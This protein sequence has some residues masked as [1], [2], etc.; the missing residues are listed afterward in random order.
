MN[1]K[2]TTPYGEEAITRDL[3]ALA[4]LVKEGF[5]RMEGPSPRVLQAIH[6]EAIAQSI[7]RRAHH[8]FV[9]TARFAVAAAVLVL[10]CGVSLQSWRSWH[11]VRHDAQ[12]VQLLRLSTQGSGSGEHELADSSELANFLLSMQ[13]FDRDS[14]FSS[15]DG[16]ESLWL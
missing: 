5:A 15:P 11:N 3:D 12:T 7:R 16:T 6:E 9:F 8:R 4:P 14:Y 2:T 10:L 1:M 13:G